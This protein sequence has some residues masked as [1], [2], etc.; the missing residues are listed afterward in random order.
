MTLEVMFPYLITAAASLAGSWV[1]IKSA[2]RIHDWRLNEQKV[3]L[4]K[5]SEL[6]EK[7]ESRLT[8]L[9]AQSNVS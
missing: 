9:E 4:I 1:A 7:T 3:L 6:H 2:L 8:Y 5:H